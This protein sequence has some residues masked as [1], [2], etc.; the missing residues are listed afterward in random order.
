MHRGF[1][2]LLAALALSVSLLAWG[3]N[4]GPQN[5]PQN[6]GDFSTNTSPQ[7][8]VPKDV[9]IV[10]GAWASASDSVTPLPED[11]TV[12]G[13]V[14]KSDYFGLTYQLPPNWVQKYKGAPPSETGRYVLAQIRP[15]NAHKAQTPGTIL[16][17]ADDMFF[18]PLPASNALELINFHKANLKA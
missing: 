6:G 3:Q 13:N 17:T 12:T 2:S 1:L 7:K 14:F 11:G 16:I 8:T 4:A 5:A 15:D 18:T 9:V 10:K